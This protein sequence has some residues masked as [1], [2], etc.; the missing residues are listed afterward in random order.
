MQHYIIFLKFLFAFF[1]LQAS[2]HA[3]MVRGSVLLHTAIAP[4]S[5]RDASYQVSALQT[6]ITLSSA[7]APSM[8]TAV[9]HRRDHCRHQQDCHQHHCSL[10]CR[11]LSRQR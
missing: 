2:S 7:Q 10:L 4:S 3:G 6:P 8:L 1:I 5:Q 9:C 11:C